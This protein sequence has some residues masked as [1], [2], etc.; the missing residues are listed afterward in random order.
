MVL[1]VDD[2]KTKRKGRLLLALK[3]ILQ[4]YGAAICI[5][6]FRFVRFSCVNFSFS[7]PVLHFFSQQNQ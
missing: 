2:V 6:A 3:V 5:I 4:A 1:T 7:L